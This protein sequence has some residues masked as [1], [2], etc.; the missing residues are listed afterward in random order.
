LLVRV[1]ETRPF[2]WAGLISYSVFLWHEP[3][4]RWLQGHGLTTGG[5]T[6]LVT[7][8]LL[9]LAITAVLSTLTYRCVE[10]PALRRKVGGSRQAEPIPQVPAE[11]AQA[12]P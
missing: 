7:N 1:L 2:V 12:A 9:L 5:V 8:T 4:V 6:G 3:I 11:Q 10:L